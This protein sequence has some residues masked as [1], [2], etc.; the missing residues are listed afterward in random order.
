MST[1]RQEQLKQLN[2]L[3]RAITNIGKAMK[4]GEKTEQLGYNNG[5]LANKYKELLEIY[6]EQFTIGN[7]EEYDGPGSNTDVDTRNEQST[8]NYLHSNGVF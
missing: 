6:Q 7:D 2:A 1:L 5:A 3:D 8:R 4:L